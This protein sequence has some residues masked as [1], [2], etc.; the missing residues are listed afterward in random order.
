MVAR[1][2]AGGIGA[3]AVGIS[4]AF[5]ALP[6]LDRGS[7]QW[8]KAANEC[9]TKTVPFTHPLRTGQ[10]VG[11][12]SADDTISMNP[13]RLIADA[14]QEVLGL[15]ATGYAQRQQRNDIRALGSPALATL[16][17]GIHQMKRAGFII[18]FTI[19]SH[20]IRNSLME[21]SNMVARWPRL[22][23]RW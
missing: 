14:K 20:G 6:L 1:R 17:L 21:H 18:R 11:F 3:L 15:A 9:Q 5:T 23:A 4:A 13:D 2:L 16:K 7:D 19:H 22:M 8:V 10:V 12:L